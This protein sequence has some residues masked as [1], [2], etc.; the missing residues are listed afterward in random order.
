MQRTFCT[1]GQR[2][3][4]NLDLLRY[5]HT[6]AQAEWGALFYVVIIQDPDYETVTIKTLHDHA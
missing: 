6:R 3:C 1:Y 2:P 4:R 5:D